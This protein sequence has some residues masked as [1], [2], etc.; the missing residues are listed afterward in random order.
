MLSFLAFPTF[1][2]EKLC[3]FDLFDS[4][5]FVALI[6][7]AAF[8]GRGGPSLTLLGSFAWLASVGLMF[9]AAEMT[10]VLPWTGATTGVTGE[11]SALRLR[12]SLETGLRSPRH[13]ASVLP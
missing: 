8:G 12:E 9:A 13:T 4:S 1:P 10:P 2:F 6:F 3:H 7:F 11:P 5:S